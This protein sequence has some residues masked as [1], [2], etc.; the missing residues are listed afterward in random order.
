M[1]IVILDGYA[2]NPGDLSWDCLDK[3][4][5]V[6]VYDRTPADK[7]VERA[8]GAEILI[9]NKTPLTRETLDRLPDVRFIPLLSTGFNVVDINACR[10]RGIPVANIPSYSVSS[11]AQ[12]TFAYILEF[13]SRVGEHSRSVMNGEWASNPDF[14]YQVAPLCELKGKTIG[15]IGY[16]RIGRRVCA[17]AKAFEMRVLVNTAHPEKYPGA[18]VEFMSVDGLLPLCDFVTVHCPQTPETDRMVNAE[19]ISKMKRGAFFI[20]TSRGGEVDEQALA[21]ALNSGYL[22]GAGADVLST[23]P[24]KADNPLLHAKNM[25][26]T[27]HIAWA[28]FE[29]RQRLMDI[30][31]ENIEGFLSGNLVNI[32]NL[33]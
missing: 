5:D 30:L 32:V 3:F 22:A 33:P 24:P 9:T 20:N 4:G 8:R 28:A 23:E 10:E 25:F 31:V 26:I 16:G 29:T 13:A 18:D 19:F 7:I 6:T 11:V 15:V 17:L 1:K 12:M 27:P 2:E 14:S 21:D